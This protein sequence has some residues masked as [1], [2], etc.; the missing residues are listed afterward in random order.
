M[1]KKRGA[2]KKPN[3]KVIFKNDKNCKICSYFNIYD[4][5]KRDTHTHQ[6]LSAVT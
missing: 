3:D 2:K 4:L 6:K 1:N 5:A